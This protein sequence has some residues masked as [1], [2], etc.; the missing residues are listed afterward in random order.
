MNVRNKV[1]KV[2]IFGDFLNSLGGT[3]YYNVNLAIKLKELGYEV[4]VYIGEQAKDKTWTNILNQQGI[5]VKFSRLPHNSFTERYQEQEFVKLIAEEFES[6]KPDIIHTHPFGK[7]AIC[8]FSEE[9]HQDIPLVATEWTTPGE[10]TSHWYQPDT[11][12]YINNV[13]AFIATCEASKKGIESYNNYKGRI[14]KIPHIIAKPGFLP[15]V[16]PDVKSI[17]CIGRLS[18]EKGIEFL[19]GAMSLVVAVD[20]EVKLTVYGKGMDNTRLLELSN[21]LGLAKNVDF[22]GSY[23]PF[24]GIDKVA[25]NH[26]IFVQPSLFESIPTTV[27]EL[28]GRKRSIIA[29]KVGGIPEI[30]S[31][32]RGL[33]IDAANTQAM[34]ESIIGLVNNQ[35]LRDNIS[36]KAYEYFT[37]NYDQS[38]VVSSICNL[39]EE[40]AS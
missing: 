14:E 34:A 37:S 21:C 40:V 18:V 32:D 36:N 23:K 28:M 30:L 6:W 5:D 7:M 13:S 33:L 29:T 38:S 20:P 39:Y 2:A 22:A 16:C 35:S 26:K 12:D 25:A 1:K 4:R 15:P 17:G 19:L 3:E 27:I 31:N 8:W 24:T 9:S 10:N 11:K